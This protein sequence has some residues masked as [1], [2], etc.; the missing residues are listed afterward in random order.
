MDYHPV[1]QRFPNFALAHGT[2]KY[3]LKIQRLPVAVYRVFTFIFYNFGFIQ[4]STTK[5]IHGYY[6][7]L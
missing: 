5:H 1:E 4:P 7:I 3:F 2:R 6:Y